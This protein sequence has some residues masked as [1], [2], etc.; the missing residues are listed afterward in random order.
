MLSEDA[1]VASVDDLGGCPMNL[2]K[3]LI[4][5]AVLACG[6]AIAM[7]QESPSPQLNRPAE[8][9]QAQVNKPAEAPWTKMNKRADCDP[10]LA[11][12]YRPTECDSPLAQATQ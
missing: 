12:I 11:Q 7:A 10:P 9:P 6:S 1:R 4:T 3:L 2:I 8:F 5:V